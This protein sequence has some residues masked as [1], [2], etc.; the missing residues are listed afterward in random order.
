MEILEIVIKILSFIWAIKFIA[1]NKF[2]GN[3]GWDRWSCYNSDSAI[4]LAQSMAKGFCCLKLNEDV[5]T[6]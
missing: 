6:L 4:F 1:Y 2:I 5:E 3:L